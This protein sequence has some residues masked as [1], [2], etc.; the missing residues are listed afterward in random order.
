MSW[1]LT[2]A[3]VFRAFR[4]FRAMRLITRIDTLKNLVLALFSVVPKMTAIFMLLMLIFYIFAVM[5]TTLF[6]GLHDDELVE[7][8]YFETLYDSLFTLFQMMTLV[9]AVV[10]LRLYDHTGVYLLCVCEY[11][12]TNLLL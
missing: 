6:K 11:S 8:P 10:E 1:A 9:S 2:G 4:I 7:Y 12:D 5:F 3:Q